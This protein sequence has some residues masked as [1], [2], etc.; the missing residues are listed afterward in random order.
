MLAMPKNR[1]IND[2]L[3]NLTPKRGGRWIGLTDADS[4]GQWVFEDGQALMPSDYSNW[5]PGEPQPYNGRSGCAAYGHYYYRHNG[6]GYQWVEKQCNVPSHGFVCQLKTGSEIRQYTSL[7]CWG[8]SRSDPAIPS[9]EEMDT[10]DSWADGFFDK[11]Q[12]YHDHHNPI[13]KCY[14]V[15]LSRGY[16][17]F[18]VMDSGACLSSADAHNTYNKHGP[19]TECTADGEGGKSAISVYQITS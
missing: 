14:K 13:K 12:I 3:F 9:L 16:T 6:R 10:R 11:K 19:S 4:D 15:A 18:G 8:N 1:V 5:H 2:F 7:G 17:V